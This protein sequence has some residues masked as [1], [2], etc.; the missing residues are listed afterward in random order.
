MLI[1][2]SMLE[3]EEDRQDFL[4]LYELYTNTMILVAKKFFNQ[5]YASAEDAV[6]NAWLKAVENFSKIWEIPC[7]KKGGLISL[8]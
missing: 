7:K 8:L 1:F 6:Q 4:N 5:D 3:S 2:L